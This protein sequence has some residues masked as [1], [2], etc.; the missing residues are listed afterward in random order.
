MSR[1]YE[2]LKLNGFSVGSLTA[3]LP[4]DAEVEY[5]E[6]TNVQYIDTGVTISD[7]TEFEFWFSA[8]GYS[9]SYFPLFGVYGNESGSSLGVQRNSGGEL[10]YRITVW[11]GSNS[12]QDIGSLDS[13]AYEGVVSLHSG[14]FSFRGQT[15]TISSGTFQSSETAW[16]GRIN[17]VA[18]YFGSDKKLGFL[19]IWE[20][21]VLVRDFIPVRVGSGSSAVGCM[22]DRVSRKLFRN[23]GTGSFTIGPD[24][25]TPVMG[26]HFFKSQIKT[27]N[28]YVQNGLIAMWDGIEN[29]GY[30]QH[31]DNATSWADLTGKGANWLLK[32]SNTTQVFE[33]GSNYVKILSNVSYNGRGHCT[34]SWSS[35]NDIIT[36]EIVLDNTDFDII[37]DTMARVVSFGVGSGNFDQTIHVKGTLLAPNIYNKYGQVSLVTGTNAVSL[38]IGSQPV[39]LN[40]LFVQS[41][42]RTFG[43]YTYEA[44]VLGAYAATAAIGVKVKSLRIYGRSLTDAERLANYAIDKVRFNLT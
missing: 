22:Y 13:D 5:I 16:Y 1:V 9:G 32:D 35:G 11:R 43:G 31:D 6:L 36:I 12:K 37:S 26:L 18:N 10:G 27:A 41:V 17:G 33:V 39:L 23:A 14:T 15:L 44:P 7:K 21:G 30:G 3:G 2:P 40:G 29:V 4:Y 28:D 8:F 34:P 38:V 19:K 25:A 20:D 42:N 24:V